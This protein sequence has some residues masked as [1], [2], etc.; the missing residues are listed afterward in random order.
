MSEIGLFDAIYTSSAIRHV[1]TDPV[2][3]EL[4]EQVIEAGIRPPSAVNYQNWLFI[5]VKDRA[6][7]EQIGRLFREAGE[8]LRSQYAARLSDQ[9]QHM[10]ERGFGRLMSSAAY[11]REHLADAPVLLFA[12]LRA[13]KADQAIA[14]ETGVIGECN[15]L[16]LA[17]HRLSPRRLQAWSRQTRADG[18]GQAFQHDGHAMAEKTSLRITAATVSAG[19][20]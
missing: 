7:R 8:R 16:C 6:L 15:D 10:S 20:R 14:G 2:P 1:K 13:R 4:I 12:C 5:V 3:D 9:P 11:L 19:F 17:A 18:T